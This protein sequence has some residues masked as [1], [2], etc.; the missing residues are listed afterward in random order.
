ME[1]KTT[2]S[3]GNLNKYDFLKGLIVGLIGA[4]LGTVLS[5]IE[6]L[7]TTGE[8]SIHWFDDPAN[9]AVIWKAVILTVLSYLTKN[10]ITPAKELKQLEPGLLDKPNK[11]EDNQTVAK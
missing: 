5:L 4:V 2:S 9:R 8:F 11:P 6:G 10:F 7:I 3:L 1:T